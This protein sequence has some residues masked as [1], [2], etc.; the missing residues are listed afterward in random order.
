MHDCSGCGGCTSCGSCGGCGK[1]LTV[2]QPELDFLNRLAQTPFLPVGR[3]PEDAAP[4]FEDDPAMTPVLQVLEKKGLIS[5]DDSLPLQGCSDGWY[6]RCPIRGSLALTARG[7][8]VLDLLD[9]QGI[10]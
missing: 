8:Q 1:S 7:Q 3:T 2:T 6:L 9:Y 10:L 4:L 5:I